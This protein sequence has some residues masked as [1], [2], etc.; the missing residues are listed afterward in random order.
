VIRIQESRRRAFGWICLFLVLSVP[1]CDSAGGSEFSSEFT[2]ADSSGILITTSP[3]PSVEWT[4]G[5]P[6]VNIGDADG[7]PAY[8][9]YRVRDVLRLPDGR[10]VV[11]DFNSEIRFYDARGTH[12]RTVGRRGRGPGEYEITS[13]VLLVGDSLWILDGLRGRISILDMQGDFVRSFTL[14]PTGDPMRPLLS[15]GMAGTISDSILVLVPWSFPG[16]TRGEPGVHWRVLNNLLYSREG[17][18]LGTFG[19]PRGVEM[20]VR[21][22]PVR[23]AG[24]APFGRRSAVALGDSLLYHSDAEHL[25][26]RAYDLENRLRRILRLEHTPRAITAD[27]RRAVL[28]M[29]DEPGED[30]AYMRDRHQAADLPDREPAHG[31]RMVVSEEGHLWIEEYV[32]VWERGIPGWSVVDRDGRWIATV[33]PPVRLDIR[34][35]GPWGVLGVWRVEWGVER[36]GIWPLVKGE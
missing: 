7:D 4:L 9:L 18:V 10:I 13:S 29:L 17:V 6:I 26:F 12:L 36:V 27:R 32:Y 2:S 33:R 22:T 19:P 25:E 15:Y 23:S 8:D 21:T 35:V 31:G 30:A 5:S 14:E 34:Q 11:L 16:H 1:A 24:A 28:S 20:E 3:R